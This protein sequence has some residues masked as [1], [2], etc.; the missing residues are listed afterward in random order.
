MLIKHFTKVEDHF[1]QESGRR[2]RVLVPLCGKTHD[3]LWYV[4]LL[5]TFTP[6][7]LFPLSYTQLLF[8]F[9]CECFSDRSELFVDIYNAILMSFE[10]P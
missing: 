10:F 9:T 4:L 1:S 8:L 7:M 6:S 3:L 5:F 2:L